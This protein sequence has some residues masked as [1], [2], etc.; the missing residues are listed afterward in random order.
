M[1]DKNPFKE[2][3]VWMLTNSFWYQLPVGIDGLTSPVLHPL[4]SA[5]T[6]NLDQNKRVA[7]DHSPWYEYSTMAC[8]QCPKNISIR[9]FECKQITQVIYLV[10]ISINMVLLSNTWIL[11]FM[12]KLNEAKL[13]IRE[14][15]IVGNIPV[16]VIFN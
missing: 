8:I 1:I 11:L 5:L 14:D 13:F 9:K 3:A 16:K 15:L 4:A 12:N 7:E 6:M 10:A 2:T